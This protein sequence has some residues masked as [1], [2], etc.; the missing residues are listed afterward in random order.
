MNTDKVYNMTNWRTYLDPLGNKRVQNFLNSKGIQ[1]FSSLVT[2]IDGAI[3]TNAEKL[4]LLVHPNVSSLVLVKP[5][6]YD[7]VLN[8]CLDYFKKIEEYELCAET[9]LVIK[10]LESSTE[11]ID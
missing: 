6:E 8:H 5:I 3:D 10:K 4:V 2:S 9:V 11:K 1:V 7:E